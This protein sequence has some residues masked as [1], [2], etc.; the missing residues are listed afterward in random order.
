MSRYF[1]MAYLTANGTSPVQAVEM[2]ARL[3]YDRISFRML[4]AGPG[5]VPPD[6]LGDDALYA[7]V[8]AALADHDMRVAD[9]EMIRMN[10][11][12]DLEAL[13]PFLDRSRALGAEHVLVA[14]DDTD[15]A[16]ITDTYGRL[17]DLLHSY[18]LTADLEFMPWTAVRNI[19]EARYLV[20]AVAHPAAAI[21]VD[22]LHFDRCGSTHEELAALPRE[23]LNYVQLC[24]G[25]KPYDRSVEGLIAIART[26][27]MIPG[28]GDI[29][30]AGFLA[31]LPGDVPISV[32]VP[33]HAMTAELG[34][35]AVAGR[36]LAATRAV[37]DGQ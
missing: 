10:A 6:L 36:S 30:L 22:A 5:D 3:G 35:E 27:R 9:A 24:D 29:D 16:R 11:D 20:E 1:S 31:A 37:L 18:D 17:C 12:T 7:Q 21:L 4:P 28:E 2:A 15:L 25:P 26:A 13:R 33:N 8:K 19:S 32:E 23:M 34:A 14:G